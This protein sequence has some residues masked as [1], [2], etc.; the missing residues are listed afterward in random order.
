MDI[1]KLKEEINKLFNQL[2]DNSDIDRL[3]QRVDDLEKRVSW[4]EALRYNPQV[5]PIPPAEIPPTTRNPLV[6]WGNITCKNNPNDGIT[7]ANGNGPDN[8]TFG[9]GNNKG[10]CC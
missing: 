4:L 1:K 3:K 10:S 8:I 9:N 2:D 7:F 5:Y 6:T